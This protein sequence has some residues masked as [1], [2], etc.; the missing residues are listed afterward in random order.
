MCP[1]ENYRRVSHRQCGIP[2]NARIPG[3]GIL[4][5]DRG[6]LDDLV[7]SWM[8][9]G[10]LDDLVVGS[11]GGLGGSQGGLGRSREVGVVPAGGR[12][13]PTPG[14]PGYQSVKVARRVRSWQVSPVTTYNRLGECLACTSQN[15]DPGKH[16]GGGYTLGLAKSPKDRRVDGRSV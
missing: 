8:T 3:C 13:C 16:W 5:W 7:V 1:R 11:Q 15:A 10:V 4:G 12:Y 6:V 9:S 14:Y 2:P